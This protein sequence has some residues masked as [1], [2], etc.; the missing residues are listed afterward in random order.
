[1]IS[2]CTD[3]VEPYERLQCGARIES[4]SHA[5][6]QDGAQRQ[7]ERPVQCAVATQEFGPVACPGDLS[8]TQVG[9]RHALAE[10]PVPRVLRKNRSG[11]AVDLRYDEGRACGTAGSQNP[12]EI[13]ASR[14][15][16]RGRNSW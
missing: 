3:G 11:G 14:A 9:K 12:F 2:V 13:A 7:S 16:A 15:G 5:I 1:M 4:R 6:G 8:P 10:L